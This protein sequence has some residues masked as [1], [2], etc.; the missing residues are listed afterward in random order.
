[1]PKA[2]G[3]R[4]PPPEKPTPNSRKRTQGWFS[5]IAGKSLLYVAA[6]GLV[7]V[8][9]SVIAIFGFPGERS[10]PPSGASG[11]NAPRPPKLTEALGVI[12]VTSTSSLWQGAG[13]VNIL[14]VARI[15]EPANDAV[16]TLSDEQMRRDTYAQTLN[17]CVSAAMTQRPL[18]DLGKAEVAQLVMRCFN[19]RMIETGPSKDAAV[20]AESV[21]LSLAP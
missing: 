1:M 16:Y 18:A 9:G 14:I 15:N 10:A 3:I 19:Q 8:I 21:T 7:I 11:A 2:S 5:D 13:Q 17:Y 4:P 6:F 12:E 20:T